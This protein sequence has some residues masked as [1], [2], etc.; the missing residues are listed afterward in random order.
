MTSRDS[1][2][3]EL[4][5]AAALLET[6][7]AAAGARADRIL[8]DFPDHIEAALLLARSRR[9]L[10][11]PEGALAVLEAL[12]GAALESAFLQLELAGSYRACGKETDALIALRRAAALDAGLADAWRELAASLFAT[13]ETLE[14]DA[15]Y[16]RFSRLSPDPPELREAALALDKDRIQAAETLLKEH[17]RRAPENV[18]AL[19]MLAELKIRR[20]EYGEAERLLKACL[21]IAPGDAVARYD[22]A[23][24]LHTLQRHTEALPMVER[25]LAMAPRHMEY[26]GLKARLLRLAGRNDEAVAIMA[27]LVAEHPGEEGAWLIFGHLLRSVGEQARAVEMYR[28]ALAVRPTS[29]PAYWSLANL[30]TFRFAADELD[31]MKELTRRQLPGSDAIQLEFAI[32]KALDDS[33]DF[34]AAFAH[35]ARGNSLQRAAMPY[36]AQALTR[37]IER[38]KAFYTAGFFAR[39]QGWGSERSDPIFIVGLPRSGSTLLEQMLSSHSQVEGTHELTDLP[40]IALELMSDPR[41]GGRENYPESIAGLGREEIE[42]L[43]E[44]YLI[45]TLSHRLSDRP[46]FVDKMLTNFAHLGLIQLMFPRAAI[47]DARRHPLGCGF[48]CYTQLFATGYAY[49]YDLG[50]LGRYIRDYVGWMDHFDEVFPGR[51][52]RV[53]YER[54][55]ADPEG[56]L[57]RLLEYCGLAYEPE[58]LRF[59]A[60]PRIVR[61]LSSEQVRQPIYSASVDHWRRYERWLGPLRATLGD[62]LDRYPVPAS[63][64]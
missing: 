23:E 54:L 50:E 21:E 26:L 41:R 15:A 49:S 4:M 1:A 17:I 34:P 30:K 59:Y 61:T 28:R 22:L 12:P 25:L 35:Y 11:D 48:S 62:V 63:P 55:V 46:R 29:G 56:E 2:D 9:R 45:R 57:R 64:T 27:Q 40:A 38:L 53:Y 36:D 18:I 10:K 8:T 47:I 13:G 16:A 24:L 60:N 6:D 43:A 32:G 51:V 20:E 7:P 31:A 44:R 3:L 5:R 37:A 42:R 14:G 33:G 58:C 52:H 39:R 19:R